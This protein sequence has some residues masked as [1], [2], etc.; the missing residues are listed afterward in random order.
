MILSVKCKVCK[1]DITVMVPRGGYNLWARGLKRIQ[2]AMPQL[3]E[4]D[5]ELLMSGIC[6]R[7]F[8]KLF[9]EK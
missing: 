1:R 6:G 5:R 7:C 8:D 2:D 3:S 9:E 4:D